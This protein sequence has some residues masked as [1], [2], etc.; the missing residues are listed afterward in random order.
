MTAVQQNPTPT[1]TLHLDGIQRTLSDESLGAESTGSASRIPKSPTATSRLGNFFNWKSPNNKSDSESSPT[2]T[3]SDRSLS[4]LPSPGLVKT[5]QMEGAISPARLTP[6]GLE[7]RKGDLGAAAYFDNPQTPLLLG[8]DATNAHVRELE[9]ELA[10]VSQEL[11]GSIRREME[12]EDEM[13]RIRAEF[14]N[15]H[16]HDPSRRGSD[17]FSDSGASSTRFPISDVDGKIELLEK[18]L[19][20]VEQHK[21]NLQAE[22]ASRVQTEL[23]RRRDLEE[24]VRD[25][26][27][28]VQQHAH[29]DGNRGSL[30][31]RLE[32][33]ES[34]LDET[35]R[36]LGQERQAKDNFEDLYTAT[37]EA[38]EK[39]RDEADNLRDE[40]VP[41]LKARVEGLE[42]DAAR[43]QQELYSL[44]DHSNSRMENITEDGG[45]SSGGRFSLGRSAS[46]ARSGSRR[47]GSISKDGGRQRSGSMSG[48][49]PEAVK[50]IEDQRDALH[51]A[52]KLL[53]NRHEKQQREH[54]RAIKNLTNAKDKAESI[55]PGN[56][57]YQREVTFLKEEVTML[58]KRTEDALEQKWQYEKGLSGL[59]MDLD[60]AEQETR[61][62]RVLLQGNGD[63]RLNGEGADDMDERITLSI[64]NAETERDQARAIA[65]D[66]RQRATSAPEGPSSQKFL[67]CA[68]R[69]DDL[70][71]Q[72]DAQVQSNQQFRE[73]LSVAVAKGE[74]EQKES[75]RKIQEMQKR[76]AGMEDSV[77]AA[78]QHS[79]TALMNHDAEMRR[80]EDATSPRLQRLTIHIPEPGKLHSPGLSPL[81]RS[82]PRRSASGSGNRSGGGSG[83]NNI[84]KLSQTSLLEMSKT[85]ILER[86][87]K[88]LEGL[89]REAEEDIQ[90]VVTRVTRSQMDVAQLQTERDAAMTQMRKL[91]DLVVAERNRADE[92]A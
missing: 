82:S 14:T 10:Y 61:G 83:S 90:T 57:T 75:T 28:Q 13:D 74:Q 43:M 30:E 68:K 4:P 86:K 17:Y 66:Y 42:A 45:N 33:L 8:D 59:K 88:E 29:G 19:R 20:K 69:M 34:S 64:S 22:T 87:V 16:P 11:A 53:I 5:V 44:R 79:E 27:D 89:L 23:S 39:Y 35:R 3:F 80:I 18:Q 67:D 70:A 51:K 21:A 81:F 32:E 41:Q 9:R 31:G 46:L 55:R 77:L 54:T 73:R 12:L 60:R 56:T 50:E 84:K 2:T 72:L 65:D 92:I 47:G 52:L 48:T 1:M 26:E 76:L 15:T 58:R 49:H 85:Q 25:L 6:S 91:Q 7:V 71:N 24:L 36:R 63:H 62:L 38:A 37:K 78:Q 40:V